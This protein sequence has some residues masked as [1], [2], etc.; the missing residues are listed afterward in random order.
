M[1]FQ[2]IQIVTFGRTG[3]TLLMSVLNSIDNTVVR[4]E[5]F[6]I[7]YHF[8][9]AYQTLQRVKEKKE[10]ETVDPFYGTQFL[11]EDVF[12]KDMSRLIK[13]Q[14]LGTETP[15]E[16]VICY[17]F[18]EIRYKNLSNEECEDFLEFMKKIFPNPCFIL[19][20][21]DVEA[22]IDSA[23]KANFYPPKER[24]EKIKVTKKID[25]F[26]RDFH[27]KN[28][29]CSFFIRYEDLIKREPILPE[30]FDFLGAK[31]DEKVL[32]EIFAVPHSFKI[33]SPSTAG[34]KIQKLKDLFFRKRN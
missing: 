25:A 9:Q 2:S 10:C 1:N 17:G 13:N 6:N 12:L 28:K 30:L 14:L 21:R 7:C 23:I 27:Q 20:T 26:L 16:E 3:S 8:F 24:A 34:S 4:G 5:N 15:E 29:D 33:N 18:K 22:A 11:N 19:L 31:Y 32:S